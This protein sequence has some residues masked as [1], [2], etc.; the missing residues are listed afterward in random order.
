MRVHTAIQI[1]NVPSLIPETRE[2]V[3]S[4]VIPEAREIANMFSPSLIQNQTKQQSDDAWSV[5][6]SM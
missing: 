5:E 2:I 1:V 6:D 4:L 3:N